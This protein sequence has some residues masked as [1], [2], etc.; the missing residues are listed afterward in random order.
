GGTGLADSVVWAWM[1]SHQHTAVMRGLTPIRED[2]KLPLFEFGS[3]QVLLPMSG[4]LYVSGRL[5]HSAGLRDAGL[6]CAAG[7]LAS[8]GVRSVVYETVSRARPRVTDDP[9][10]ISIPGA[11]SWDW[12]SFLSGHIANS[13]ACASFVGHR[14]SLGKATPLPYLASAA[15]GLGRMA[16]GRHWFSDTMTG[17]VLGF[18]IGK[19]LAARTLRRESALR[20]VASPSTS[21]IAA[22]MASRSVAIPV[23]RLSF[24]F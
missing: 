22:T 11:K 9:Y 15:I 19:A 24:D 20:Q 21:S 10:E 5:S 4:I 12:H 17:A 16:D 8:L 3:G 13:M 18:A 14:F 23:F 6:G 7:H 1:T 2:W